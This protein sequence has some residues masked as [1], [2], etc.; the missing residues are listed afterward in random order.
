MAHTQAIWPDG[1]RQQTS[2]RMSAICGVFPLSLPNSKTT[3]SSEYKLVC[4]STSLWLPIKCDGS[5][6]LGTTLDYPCGRSRDSPKIHRSHTIAI[7]LTRMHRLGKSVDAAGGPE[8]A[9]EQLGVTV[10]AA[11]NA[12]RFFLLFPTS[13]D[14]MWVSKN[15]NLPSPS[16]EELCRIRDRSDWQKLAQRCVRERWAISRLRSEVNQV[17]SRQRP[18]DEE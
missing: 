6:S 4:G 17:V 9:A 16:I 8:A 11:T 1:S 7:S 5:T 18:V 2:P 12:H 3:F 14:L 13:R 15:A 10:D